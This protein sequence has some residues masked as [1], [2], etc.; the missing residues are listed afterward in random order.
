MESADSSSVSFFPW[1]GTMKTA[2]RTLDIFEAFAEA[3]KPLS[4][5]EIARMIDSPVSSCH[6]LIRTLQKNGYMYALDVRRRYYPTRRLF[7][8]S[9]A[10]ATHDP[11]VERLTSVLNKLRDETGETIL[12]GQRQ[13]KQIIYL[14]VLES[15]LMIRYAAPVG[16]IKPLPS[17]AIGKA[18]LGEMTD[19]DLAHFFAELAHPQVTESTI[20]NPD[21]LLADIQRARK[22][23]YFV[24]RGENVP[25]VMAIART[26]T[27]DGEQ[28]AIAVAG[29]MHRLEPKLGSI[30][31]A[32]IQATGAVAELA[33]TSR[34]ASR[35]AA[36]PKQTNRIT[37]SGE[38]T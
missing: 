29:P 21:Q 8:V 3:K 13:D 28:L 31:D 36:P 33:E 7:E 26:C 9:S 32:L 16:A 11:I 5:S 12:L 22:R 2:D 10:I 38:Q 24:T 35:Q 20:T 17:T 6:A 34:L 14:Q 4:L 37:L 18:F 1:D 15:P 30:G 27:L 25:D 23:G 19:E